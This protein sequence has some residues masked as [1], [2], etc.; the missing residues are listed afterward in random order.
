MYVS[1]QIV[2]MGI[3]EKLSTNEQIIISKSPFI[4]GRV[5][6]GIVPDY[7]LE[8]KMVSRLHLKIYQRK[9]SEE[10]IFELRDEHSLNGTWVNGERIKNDETVQIKD[11]D[12]LRIVNE[13]FIFHIV[14]E[15][16]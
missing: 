12:E 2:K 11:G 16:R 4:I 1:E 5:S 6:E 8:S 15:I 10:T 9:C 3:L 13:K 14:K 7:C